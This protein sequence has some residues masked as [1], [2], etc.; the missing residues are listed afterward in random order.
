MLKGVVIGFVLAVII[1]GGGLY[2]YFVAGMAP[3]GPG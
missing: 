3:L 1:F 2:Y